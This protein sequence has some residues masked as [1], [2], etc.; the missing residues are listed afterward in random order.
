MKITLE[1]KTLV[2]LQV[3]VLAL[4]IICLFKNTKESFATQNSSYTETSGICRTF[5]NSSPPEL[6]HYPN[7]RIIEYNNTPED[8]EKCKELCDV[9]NN[10]VGY[11][12]DSINRKCH[13]YG[14]NF[15]K[16]TD[17]E[18]AG[19]VSTIDQGIQDTPENRLFTCHKKQGLPPK[20]SVML[21]NRELLN[22]NQQWITNFDNMIDD[23]IKKQHELISQNSQNTVKTMENI[24]RNLIIDTQ[25]YANENTYN[26]NETCCPSI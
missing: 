24:V 12:K 20:Q 17:I 22:Q 21:K 14:T 19:G 15:N 6:T 25:R 5:D 10:C 16:K 26:L 9:N 2:I 23:K 11:S 3:F 1:S 4:I 18:G 13:L 7:Y 8:I